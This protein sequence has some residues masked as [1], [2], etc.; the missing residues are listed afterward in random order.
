MSDRTVDTTGA[1]IY[2]TGAFIRPYYRRDNKWCWIVTE[3]N[4]EN[5]IDGD[6]CNIKE[7]ADSKDKLIGVYD[8]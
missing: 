7:E 4:D 6:S 3:F 8:D 2:T 5:F 1:F